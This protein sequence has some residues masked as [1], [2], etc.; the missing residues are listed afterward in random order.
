MSRHNIVQVLMSGILLFGA[1]AAHAAADHMYVFGDSL[2]DTGHAPIFDENGKLINIGNTFTNKEDTR[3]GRVWVSY[4][5]TLLGLPEP[6]PRSPLWSTRYPTGNVERSNYAVA[7]YNTRQIIS[8][9]NDQ[10]AVKKETATGL[11]GASVFFDKK[12]YVVNDGF[13]EGHEKI[14]DKNI[15]TLWGGGN[16]LLHGGDPVQ[17]ARNIVAS[18]KSIVDTDS[19]DCLIVMDM[20]DLGRLPYNVSFAD[21]HK[22][23][24]DEVDAHRSALANRF[25]KEL[26]QGL[27][28]IEG[29]V[30]LVN[31]S[32]LL[33]DILDTPE[34]YGYLP[35]KQDRFCL[36]S[37][38]VPCHEYKEKGDQ[39]PQPAEVVFY[40]G[41]HPTTRTHRLFAEYAYRSL[42][43][44][45]APSGCSGHLDN[46]RVGL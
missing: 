41:I 23:N 30:L 7:G 22:K 6:L 39:S 11:K 12:L 38:T 9:I 32:R 24:I 40:D 43:Q 46:I 17:A 33:K 44:P 42:S 21:T 45:G 18:A 5:A 15:A 20:P 3:P 10:K 16:D 19:F 13:K 28:S 1:C 31:I 26:K 36:K 25:N 14:G 29:P 2:S 8:S 35:I 27:D 4:L 34:K 37:D